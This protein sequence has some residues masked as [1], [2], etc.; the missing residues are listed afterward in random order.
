MSSTAPGADSSEAPE[1]GDDITV[2]LLLPEKDTARYE[3]FDYPLIKKKVAEL[4]NGKGKVVYANA[5]ATRTS[6]ASSSSR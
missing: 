4:T 5:E 6:R 3:K 2:G 1:K